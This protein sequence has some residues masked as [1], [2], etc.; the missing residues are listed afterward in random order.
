[1]TPWQEKMIAMA[2]CAVIT[3]L[4]CRNI[5]AIGRLSAAMWV[6]VIGTAVW[7]AGSGLVHFNAAHAF[8]FPRGALT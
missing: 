5:R 6:V 2:V 3:A 7:A 4:L 1:M 8:N